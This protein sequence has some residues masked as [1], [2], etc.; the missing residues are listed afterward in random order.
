MKK[1]FS[2]FAV[3]SAAL[4]CLPAMAQ[5]SDDY[6]PKDKW[7]YVYEKFQEGVVY[8]LRGEKTSSER[9][10]VCVDNGSLHF[11]SS[12]DVILQADMTPIA[13]LVIGSKKFQ[14]V[15]GKLMEVAAESDAGLVLWD[16]KVTAGGGT[17]IGFGIQSE[18]FAA[19][20]VDLKSVF[21]QLGLD[22]LNVPVEKAE[23]EQKYGAALDV[24]KHL[25]IRTTNGDYLKAGKSE[26][27]EFVGKDEAKVFLKDHKV[28][29]ND[30][31][32]LLQVVE[33]I[34]NRD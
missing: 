12:K 30:P 33:Y 1:I 17:D 5:N 6:T 34:N 31:L 26:F 24:E 15:S 20:N 14:N 19:Q 28:K 18:G 10:N 4:F 16:L 29:W 23:E 21:V 27:Q 32:S 7:P 22:M 2:F 11:L 3:A 13:Y 8:G 9:Y 25:Y